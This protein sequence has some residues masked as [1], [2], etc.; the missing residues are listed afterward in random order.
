MSEP[1]RTPRRRR[2]PAFSCEGCRRR[3][4]KCDRSYPCQRCRQLNAEC[5]YP[6]G[7]APLKPQ[8]IPAACPHRI[9]EPPTPTSAVPTAPL[10]PSSLTISSIRNECPQTSTGKSWKS[11]N[12]DEENTDD[13]AKVRALLEKVQRLEHLLSEYKPDGVLGNS[14]PSV[15]VESPQL[16]G[17]LSKTRFYGQSH[18]MNLVGLVR[19]IR[20]SLVDR[21]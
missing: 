21:T 19:L 17:T 13:S 14:N 18:W 4:I 16:R 5:I 15:P 12:T 2:R 10:S 1:C 11:P 6:E 3:K 9:D 7:A 8:I 20:N